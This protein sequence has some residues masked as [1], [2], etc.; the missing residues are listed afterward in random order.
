[1]G[2]LERVCGAETSKDLEHHHFS[3]DVDVLGAVGMAGGIAFSIY[4]VKYLSDAKAYKEALEQFF[5]WTCK[6]FERK[7]R[8]SV[9]TKDF[10]RRIF[11]HWVGDVCPR[12]NGASKSTICPLCKGSGKKPLNCSA[13][14]REIFE[15]VVRVADC[16]VLKIK[17][18]I[19]KKMR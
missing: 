16:E 10:A 5:Q 12:C 6:E 3:C 14:D 17:R 8:T 7:G 19:S 11:H 9:G 18:L 1:M 15:T 13:C 2:I 4:R